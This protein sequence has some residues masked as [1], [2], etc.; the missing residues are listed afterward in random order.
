VGPSVRT[1][2][3]R[4]SRI[5]GRRGGFYEVELEA[6]GTVAVWYPELLGEPEEGAEILVNTSALDL[7]LGTG[8]LDFVVAR[9]DRAFP[10]A[11]LPGRGMKARYTPWQVCVELAEETEE[12]RKALQRFTGLEGMPVVSC[13]LHSQVPASVAGIRSVRP[14][15]KVVYIMTDSASLPISFSALS[16][17]LKSKGWVAATITCGQA[18]GGDLEAVN[19]FSALALSKALLGADC[20]V[21]GPGPGH[22][23]T[24]S[25]WGFTG[26]EQGW[27]LDATS[28]LGGTPIA[29][30]RISF[31]DPR[32]RHQGLSHHSIT[33]LSEVVK[34]RAIVAVPELHPD[35]K[36]EVYK[37]LIHTPIPER[38]ELVLCD[39][40]EALELLKAEFPNLKTMERGIDQDPPFFL[41]ACAAGVV[42]GLRAWP[43][44]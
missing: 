1:V 9:L 14:T 38:H 29:T 21:V 27:T 39:A 40:S 22:L 33:V 2:L 5:L 16:T 8:G 44:G 24:G 23:G 15:A 12:G 19:I 26:V 11:P 4:V 3:D 10:G 31:A 18:Y 36:A 34:S 43:K 17:Q 32:R 41:A 28:T 25:K 42:A 6:R 13:L 30:L 20:V 37:T 7:G 35:Q